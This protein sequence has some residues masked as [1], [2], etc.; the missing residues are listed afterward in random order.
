MFTPVQ[1]CDLKLHSNNPTLHAL[2]K[3]Q[4]SNPTT[5][6]EEWVLFALKLMADENNILRAEV[7]RLIQESPSPFTP[8]G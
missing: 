4:E 7:V 8:Y 5:P 2:V 6:F 1:M 3:L